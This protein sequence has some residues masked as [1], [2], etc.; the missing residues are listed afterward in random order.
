MK[1]HIPLAIAYDFDG[2]LAPGNM[3]EHQFIPNIK[4]TKAAFWK[5][6]GQIAKAEQADPE[7]VGTYPA[8]ALVN[9]LLRIGRSREAAA[10]ARKQSLGDFYAEAMERMR[11]DFGHWVI[12]E[13]CMPFNVSR[14][15]DESDEDCMLV[16]TPMTDA[17]GKTRYQR[18]VSCEN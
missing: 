8:E 13:H 15:Y 5:E 16:L 18:S 4:M 6:V 1:K 12:F 10:L 2:T 3:Q 14:A 17:K 7:N 11:P 9:L